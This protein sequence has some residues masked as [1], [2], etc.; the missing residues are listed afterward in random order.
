MHTRIS[1]HEIIYILV[2]FHMKI[3]RP[4]IAVRTGAVCKCTDTCITFH[5][6]KQCI[7]AI[8]EQHTIWAH[9]I[10]DGQLLFADVLTRLHKFD[11]CNTDHR[12]DTDIRLH[13]VR[14]NLHLS[15]LTDTHLKHGCLCVLVNPAKCQWH[16]DLGIQIAL[17]LVDI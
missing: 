15:R 8:Y 2:I 5:F 16:T 13:H 3:L 14:Q 11:M 17:G 7:V 12:H 9:M 4:V 10:D 1:M 6:C